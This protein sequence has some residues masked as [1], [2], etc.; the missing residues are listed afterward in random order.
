MNWY[1]VVSALSAVGGVLISALGF[2]LAFAKKLSAEE[3]E[4]GTMI[5]QLSDIRESIKALRVLA[6]RQERSLSAMESRLS[7]MEESVLQTQNR[8]DRFDSRAS[9][10]HDSA[11]S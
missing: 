4:L 8:M 11:V 3:R 6:D 10:G 7:R 2:V 1:G 5:S 9:H